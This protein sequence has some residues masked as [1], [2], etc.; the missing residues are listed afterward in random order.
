MYFPD[1]TVYFWNSPSTVVFILFTSTP[2]TSRASRSSQPRPQI[3]L[4]T[5]HPAPRNVASSSWMIF[6]LPRTGPSRRCRLQFTTKIRLSS[7]SRAAIESPAVASGSSISPSPTKHQ[8]LEPLVSTIS[9]WSR[10]RLK[11]AW[12]TAL[13]GPR[14]IETVG[15]SQ[16]SGMRRGC[17]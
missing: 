11:R 15:N 8:T 10:Y 7:C 13:R 14:P 6:P 9:W 2:S 16:N 3:T 17:G 12:Y 1:S 4:M 5:F